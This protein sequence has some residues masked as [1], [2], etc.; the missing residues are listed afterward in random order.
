MNSG[1]GQAT[2]TAQGLPVLAGQ[3]KKYGVDWRATASA[4]GVDPEIVVTAEARI[5]FKSLLEM[6]ESAARQSGNDAFGLEYGDA[7]PVNFAGA[8]DYMVLN[9]PDLRTALK[10]IARYVGLVVD[11][12]TIG[13][14]EGAIF[15]FLTIEISDAF[16]ARAQFEDC[17]LTII[18]KRIRHIAGKPDFAVHLDFDHPEPER[19]KMFHNVLGKYLRFERPETRAG[20]ERVHLSKPLPAADPNLYEIIRGMAKQVL[21]ERSASSDLVFR[22]TELIAHRLKRGDVSLT[23]IAHDLDLSPRALQRELD[24]SETNFRDLV[25]ET[26]KGMAKRFLYETN[27]PMTEI[28]FLVGFSE[29]SAFSR[30]ARSW[31]G[32]TPRELRKLQKERERRGS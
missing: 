2:I 28:A 5:P 23:S 29:L 18:T 27:L 13:Y 8:L 7:L 10:D 21:S 16:G 9:A 30:A 17:V 12:Y 22:A 6:L 14:E 1:S 11:A 26:R 31:F 19:L 25:E 32:D 24:H 4:A 20:V 15:G 3:M